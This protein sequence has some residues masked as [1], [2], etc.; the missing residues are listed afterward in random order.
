MRGTRVAEEGYTEAEV[1]AR[2]IPP[3]AAARSR[4]KV[5]CEER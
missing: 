5:N 2:R 1:I 3:G 4:E